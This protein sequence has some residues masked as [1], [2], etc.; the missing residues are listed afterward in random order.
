M[1]RRGG[2]VKEAVTRI[3]EKFH[4]KTENWLEIIFFELHKFLLSSQYFQR[5]LNFCLNFFC[6]EDQFSQIGKKSAHFR[7]N[8][9]GVKI[10]RFYAMFIFSSHERKF[11]GIF[12]VWFS[13]LIHEQ[14]WV[15]VDNLLLSF[16]LNDLNQFSHFSHHKKLFSCN[17]ITLTAACVVI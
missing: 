14:Y 6:L 8:F 4:G 15:G 9:S 17:L 1:V 7:Y 16:W 3:S 10:E 2:E 11:F 12:C 13:I 5:Q